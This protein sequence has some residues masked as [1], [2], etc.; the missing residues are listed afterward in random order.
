MSNTVTRRKLVDGS[1]KFVVMAYGTLDASG[2]VILVDASDM[3]EA[4]TKLTVEKIQGTFVR[5]IAEQAANNTT[6]VVSF[7][8]D[9]DDTIMYLPLDHDFDFDFTEFGGVPNPASTGYTGDIL[10]TAT[11]T[12]TSTGAY[13]IFITGR[14]N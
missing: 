10:L 9:A 11:E 1:H 3:V 5:T 6:V 7:D 13:T 8:A 14:K 12:G 2:S 4:P